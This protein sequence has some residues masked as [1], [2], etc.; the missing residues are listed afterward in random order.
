MVTRRNFLISG[1]FLT[2]PACRGH[3]AL[4]AP[5]TAV[6]ERP[7][8]I[9][10]EG[11]YPGWPWIASAGNGILFCV[12]RE[13]TVH[14]YSP[15]GKVL[16]VRSN[17][18]G[19]T[20]SRAAVVVDAP[21]V[22]D[23]NA[24]IAVLPNQDLL[25]TYNTYTRARESLAL[26]VRS[27]DTGRTW[28]KPQPVGVTN[29]RTRSAACVL[30]NGA[31]LLPYY[32]APGNGALAALSPNNGLSWKTVRIPDA[33][34]FV[35]DE[36]DVLEVKPERLVGILRNS[37]PRSDGTFW[38][39]QSRNGGQTWSVPQ[40]TNV[41]SQRHP[42]PAQITFQ[43]KT[44]TLI[45]ADQRMVSVSAVRPTGDDLLRW[46]LKKRWPC[47]QYNPAGSPILDSSYPCSVSVGPRQRLIVDYEIRPNSRRIAGYFVRFPEDW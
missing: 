27:S 1:L 5:A 21:E 34:G 22:D 23:R 38:M 20:W 35:G 4:S 41:R 12:F 29:T 8:V 7:D 6:K 28:S 36:W 42:S 11:T 19:K 17:D 30:A 46:D 32:V 40:P 24:A 39:T 37:H 33:D 47:F 3:L 26:T 44:P 14:D 43:G 45:Y 16:M 18:R 9:L 15:S 10:Y 25:V 2:A 31:L 13:G